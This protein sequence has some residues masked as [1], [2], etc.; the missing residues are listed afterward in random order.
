[1]QDRQAAIR[2]TS[3]HHVALFDPIP[4]TSVLKDCSRSVAM[5]FLPFLLLSLAITPASL[6]PSPT[7]VGVDGD[8]KDISE[9]NTGLDL[10]DG[11]IMEHHSGQRSAILGNQYRWDRYIPYVLNESLSLNSKGVI[12]RAFE[13]L[14]LKACIDFKPRTTEKDYITLL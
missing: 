12:L 2:I 8:R 3:K 10:S 14:R 6:M 5:D 1:M 11:D 7:V 13:Q 4:P 9:I